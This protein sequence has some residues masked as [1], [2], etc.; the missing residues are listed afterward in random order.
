MTVF[1]LYSVNK[2]TYIVYS[3]F[4]NLQLYKAQ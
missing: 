1:V 2:A 3:Y 4:M